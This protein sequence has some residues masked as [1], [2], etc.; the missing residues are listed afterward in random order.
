MQRPPVPP[1]IVLGLGLIVAWLSTIALLSWVIS[2]AS[3][4]LIF[5]AAAFLIGLLLVAGVLYSPSL[6]ARATGIAHAREFAE[7]LALTFIGLAYATVAFHLL[8]R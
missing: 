1:I 8:F 4:Y 2:Q 6:L 7:S 3:W 5:S